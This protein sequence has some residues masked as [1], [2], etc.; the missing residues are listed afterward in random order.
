M[1][2][3]TKDKIFREELLKNI[4]MMLSMFQKIVLKNMNQQ[5]F[6][7]S[8]FHVLF[9]LILCIGLVWRQIISEQDI[10]IQGQDADEPDVEL[11]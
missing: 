5:S 2:K 11:Q 9:A 8:V 7:I 10:H 6:Y 1:L 4:K 3:N